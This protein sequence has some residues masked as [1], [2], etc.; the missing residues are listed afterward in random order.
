MDPLFYILTKK[1]QNSSWNICGLQGKHQAFESHLD[2][3]FREGDVRAYIRE[4]K[5][6]FPAVFFFVFAI[7]RT[8]KFL[9]I[10]SSSLYFQRVTRVLDNF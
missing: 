1:I 4:L 7:F 2:P 5:T 10:S 3:F 9:F 6:R 8:S